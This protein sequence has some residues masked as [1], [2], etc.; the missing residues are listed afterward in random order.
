[1]VAIN[2]FHNNRVTKLIKIRIVSL[3]FMWVVY[4]TE[5]SIIYLST[6]KCP[7]QKSCQHLRWSV[8][9]TKYT[10]RIVNEFS[11]FWC[12]KLGLRLSLRPRS[13]ISILAYAR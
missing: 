6:V 11:R 8:Y 9:N 10:K 2:E 13:E 7:L 3:S 12:S 5:Q 1:M 4:S